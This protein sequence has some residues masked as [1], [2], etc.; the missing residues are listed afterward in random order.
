MGQPLSNATRVF[1]KDGKERHTNDRRRDPLTQDKLGELKYQEGENLSPE[2]VEKRMVLLE[3]VTAEAVNRLELD[4]LL[5]YLS[6]YVDLSKDYRCLDSGCSMGAISYVLEG[7]TSFRMVGVDI[8]RQ[9]VVA[10]NR[11]KKAHGFKTELL[12]GDLENLCF[13]DDS[14]D[15]VLVHD[16]L[17]HFPDLDVPLKAIYR[18]LKKGGKLV[19]DDGNM[20]YWPI[21]LKAFKR[22]FKKELWGSVNEWPITKFRLLKSLKR[23]EF[24]VTR[25]DNVRYLPLRFA[26]NR[27]DV[28]DFFS[29]IPVVNLFG[30]RIFC[31]AQ[32]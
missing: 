21:L 16:T 17:H 15:I 30:S 26:G 31:L 10:G 11:Y 25:L 13:K 29:K 6:K 1:R 18:I 23:T 19:V 3:S 32:K 8:S 22:K 24:R 2:D 14:F 12:V 7:K 4:G 28:D 27:L 5:H 9:L 20:L